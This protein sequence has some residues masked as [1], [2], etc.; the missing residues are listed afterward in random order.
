MNQRIRHID[1]ARGI[2]ITTVIAVHTGFLPFQH[3]LLPILTPWMLA[4]F[5]FVHG[6]LRARSDQRHWGIDYAWQRARSL[7]GT[8][9]LA[10]GVSYLIWLAL[11]WYAPQ[12]VLFDSWQVGLSALVRGMNLTYNGPL[13]FLPMFFIACVVFDLWLRIPRVRI[14]YMPLWALA[15]LLMSYAINPGSAKLMHSPDIALQYVGFMIIGYA[16]GRS[17]IILTA[18]QLSAVAGAFA[19]SSWSNGTVDVFARNYGIHAAYW[20]SAILGSVVVVGFSRRVDRYLPRVSR[21]LAGFGRQSLILL[22]THW[23]VMQYLTYLLSLVGVLKLLSATPTYS[24]FS[25]FLPSAVTFTIIELPLLVL[26]MVVPL[27]V[28]WIASRRRVS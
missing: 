8:Y 7:L 6:R 16:H 24:S 11:R 22:V 26:Y 14:R 15:M 5:A 18:A 3:Q 13:W 12:S 27:S 19:I 9:V 23:P 20:T 25:Y 28:A 2:A 21:V 10:G 1:V 17:R 4:V